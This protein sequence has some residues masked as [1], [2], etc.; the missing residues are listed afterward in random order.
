MMIAMILP[1]TIKVT[2]SRGSQKD[3]EAK[4]SA[5]RRIPLT[6]IHRRFALGSGDAI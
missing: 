3:D 1:T 5:R 4:N 2:R 6:E